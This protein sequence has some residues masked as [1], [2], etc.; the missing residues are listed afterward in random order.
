MWRVDVVRSS[1]HTVRVVD[2]LRS[3]ASRVLCACM[4]ATR[5]C[6]FLSHTPSYTQ[7]S[8]SLYLQVPQSLI[9]NNSMPYKRFHTKT[10]HNFEILAFPCNQFGGQE[11]D[12][13]EIVKDFCENEKEIKFCM[14]EKVTVS[15]YDKVHDVYKHLKRK[16]GPSRIQWNLGTSSKVGDMRSVTHYQVFYLVNPCSDRY[17]ILE[18]A[19]GILGKACTIPAQNAKIPAFTS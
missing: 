12:E 1:T 3:L 19:S 14:L 18:K 5:S 15:G 6:H 11:P 13:P 9:T 17:G 2:G 7:P 4:K 16:V 10:N 8:L